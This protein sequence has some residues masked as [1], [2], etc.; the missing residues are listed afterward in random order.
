MFLSVCYSPY[1]VGALRLYFNYLSYFSM[2]ILPFL[3]VKSKE[4]FLFWLKVLAW[5]FVLPILFANLDL[6][7]GGRQFQDA[8]KR[9]GGNIHAP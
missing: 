7:H 4:D 1:P 2:F 9:I 6:I 8:G 5:S 3:V